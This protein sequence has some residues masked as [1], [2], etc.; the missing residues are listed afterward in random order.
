MSKRKGPCPSKR[1]GV[2]LSLT[3]RPS[4]SLAPS[5]AAGIHSRA[6]LRPIRSRHKW[7]AVYKGG[8]LSSHCS[9][10]VFRR[11]NAHPVEADPVVSDNDSNWPG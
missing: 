11:T 4:L 3:R 6:R 2:R 7:L 10:L 1:N 8:R 9:D 5:P